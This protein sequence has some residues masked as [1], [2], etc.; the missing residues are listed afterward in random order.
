[1][2]KAKQESLEQLHVA[3]ADL[4]GQALKDMKM[5]GEY[6]AALVG[7]AITFLK[8]NKIEADLTD[9]NAVGSTIADELPFTVI[10]P[11]QEQEEYAQQM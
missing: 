11:E 10:S 5:S 7:N 1:M 2:S 3:T 4:L 6:N 9:E 8:N